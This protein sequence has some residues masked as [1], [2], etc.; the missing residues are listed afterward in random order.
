MRSLGKVEE[1][2]GSGA[3]NYDNARTHAWH[4]TVKSDIPL[5]TWPHEVLPVRRSESRS[6]RIPRSLLR[7]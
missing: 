6:E 5:E 2:A 7:G 3:A 4:G 1:Q